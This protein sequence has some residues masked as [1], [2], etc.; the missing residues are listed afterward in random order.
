M[1]DLYQFLFFFI[2]YYSNL[3]IIQAT[4]FECKSTDPC[5]CSRNNA[6][7]N[8]RTVG[9]ETV[10]YRSWGWA[11]S[12]RNSY[13]I[14]IC[15]GT[16]LSKYYILTAAHCFRKASEESLPYSV[17]MGV[18][19]LLSTSGQIR[20]V[21]EIFIHPKWNLT[22]QENDIAILKLNTAISMDDINIA[23]ICLPDVLKSQRVRYP[24]LSSS[25]VAIGWG[26]TIWDDFISP[27]YLRQVTL[28]AIDHT[29]TKCMDIIKN[30]NSQ[31]CAAVKGGGKGKANIFNNFD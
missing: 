7:I 18:D 5:G 13:D 24:K 6:D 4:I 16:I 21:S 29:E 20:I 15:G 14:H 8:L 30:I 3:F 17:A 23:K 11:V 28:E 10:A 25:L 31:F 1:I 27:M 19:S 12:V 2:C 26:I 22:N 9:G